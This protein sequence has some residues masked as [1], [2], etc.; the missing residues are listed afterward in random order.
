MTGRGPPGRPRPGAAGAA[1]GLSRREGGRG[2][3][4]GR[5]CALPPSIVSTAARSAGERSPG[6][7]EAARVAGPAAAGVRARRDR[8]FPSSAWPPVA[9][10]RPG[11]GGVRAAVHGRGVL[12]RGDAPG[13][14][15]PPPP[16]PVR[17]AASSGACPPPPSLLPC[18][19][20]GFREP[21][22]GLWRAEPAPDC[23]SLDL[24][25]ETCAWLGSF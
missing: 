6:P 25:G 17:S 14:P 20:L 19:S 21:G 22:G 16:P 11:P 12:K 7:G 13:A 8:G 18:G 9:A 15:S 23:A 10:A 3:G 1:K 4:A 5:A 24:E 2:G